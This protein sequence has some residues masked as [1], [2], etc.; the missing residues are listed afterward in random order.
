MT[1]T[2]IKSKLN[3]E[4]DKI[5]INLK[6]QTDKTISL[7]L[8]LWGYLIDGPELY[9]DESVKNAC[10]LAMFKSNSNNDGNVVV[11]YQFMKE[12][13][14]MFDASTYAAKQYIQVG[15]APRNKEVDLGQIR[16][17]PSFKGYQRADRTKD[18]T[19]IMDG[20]K[21]QYDMEITPSPDVKPTFPD[22]PDNVDPNDPEEE[23]KGIHG[24]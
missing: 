24:W 5:Y 7:H 16:Y 13:Y 23:K 6:D 11:G 10:F 15:I 12:Y 18:S 1:C 14:T 22:D 20:F 9:D 21:D 2:D 3:N 4:T 8:P 19:S 17:D